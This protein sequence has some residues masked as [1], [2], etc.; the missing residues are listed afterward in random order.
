MDTIRGPLWDASQGTYASN[1]DYVQQ[2]VANLLTT[3]FPNLRP[4]Q[5]E[6]REGG[7]RALATR[8]AGGGAR[9]RR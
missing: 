5:V 3:S 2:Y 4:T 8:P 7:E 9:L 1:K 6:V